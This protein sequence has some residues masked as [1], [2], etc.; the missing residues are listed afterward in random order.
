VAAGVTA[1]ILNAGSSNRSSPFGGNS[2][3]SSGSSRPSSPSSSST[4]SRPSTSNARRNF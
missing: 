1:A 4:S 3:R 2:N